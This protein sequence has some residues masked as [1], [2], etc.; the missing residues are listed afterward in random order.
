MFNKKLAVLI[1]IS[2]LLNAYGQEM[3]PD[4]NDVYLNKIALTE[5][6][7]TLKKYQ[8]A[9]EIFESIGDH[10][11][12][13]EYDYLNAKLNQQEGSRKIHEGSVGG[14]GGSLT[15]PEN[16]FRETVAQASMGVHLGKAQIRNGGILKGAQDV[17]LI[18]F[19][20]TKTVQ[21]LSSFG[22]GH[23]VDCARRRQKLKWK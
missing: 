9:R 1:G 2:S 23:G 16:D 10:K 14:L 19:T 5:S 8:S 7:I 3:H 4:G 21:Q 13:L 17:G 12:V 6:L 20:G 18:Q 11:G 15:T 22:C